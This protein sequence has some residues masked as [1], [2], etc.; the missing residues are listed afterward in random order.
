MRKKQLSNIKKNCSATAHWEA[1]QGTHEQAVAYVSK[2][3]TRKAGPWEIGEQLAE[4]LN[5]QQGKR[6]D[7]LS[8]KRKLDEGQTE[9]QIAEADDTFPAWAKYSRA[10]ARYNMLRRMNERTWITHTTVYW[11]PPGTGKTR[12]ALHEAGEGAYWLPKPENN[13]M[14]W[15]D[16]YEGQEVVVIDEFYGWI[17]RDKMQRMCDRY[18]LLVQTKN[19]TVPFNPKR[20]II[21]SNEHPAAWWPKVGLGAMTRRLEGTYGKIEEMVSAW[22]P[23]QIVEPAAPA[24]PALVE[25]VQVLGSLICDESPLPENPW[26]G[27]IPLEAIEAPQTPHEERVEDWL[28]YIDVERP[29]E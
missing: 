24:P 6:N 5:K 17:A 25:A 15:F 2:A 4:W 27:E 11:G 26:G 23:P 9:R 7:L 28:E 1:R 29:Q 16:G 22:Q 20:I 3:E 21:T 18:P 13:G 10:I 8:L 12:R 19:G 14:L